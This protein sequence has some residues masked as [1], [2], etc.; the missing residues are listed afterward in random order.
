VA[1]IL[2]KN[3]ETTIIGNKLS[4]NKLENV[5]MSSLVN[6]I[7]SATNNSR[8]N[9]DSNEITYDGLL[10]CSK[11]S[12]IF[13]QFILFIKNSEIIAN[14]NTITIDN[15]DTESY[16]IAG[17]QLINTNAGNQSSMSECINLNFSITNNTILTNTDKQLINSAKC[18]SSI[19]STNVDISTD[20][21]LPYYAPTGE[22]TL[23][24]NKVVPE[25]LIYKRHVYLSDI[26][27]PYQFRPYIFELPSEYPGSNYWWTTVNTD[28]NPSKIEYNIPGRGGT[29]E[30]A[31]RQIFKRA[32]IAI[33]EQRHFEIYPF[34]QIKVKG[35]RS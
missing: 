11:I 25:K 26:Y 34:Y 33:N 32:I 20:L 19:F 12:G 13:G 7:G 30:T 4:Y 22:L 2:G 29:D 31:L 3:N 10:N 23:T 18:N 35:L 28:I 6:F 15:I 24:G 9:V 27:M 16:G 14:A 5:A 1:G 21:P 17:I 8:I